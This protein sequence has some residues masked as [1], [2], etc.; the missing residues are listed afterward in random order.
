MAAGAGSVGLGNRQSFTVRVV[1]F[2][3]SDERGYAKTSFILFP[4]LGSRTLRGN[5][6]DGNIFPDLHTFFDDIETM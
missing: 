1:I 4:D 6:D 2:M 3:H 5:H